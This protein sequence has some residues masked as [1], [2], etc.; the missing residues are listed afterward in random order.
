M[1]STVPQARNESMLSAI[2][3]LH[4]AEY[5][6]LMTR[7]T[8][9]DQFGA[10]VWGLMGAYV[11]FLATVWHRA[12]ATSYLAWGSAIGVEVMLTAIVFFMGEHYS[13]VLYLETVL[14]PLVADLGVDREFW[15]YQTFLAKGRQA[16]SQM[17]W[18]WYPPLIAVVPI[19]IVL[20]WR[21]R[22]QGWQHGDWVGFLA[23][24]LPV[25]VLVFLCRGLVN[26][27]A[28]WTEELH[29]R[30]QDRFATRDEP[31]GPGGVVNEGLIDRLRLP[32]QRESAPV[33]LS[34]QDKQSIMAVACRASRHL[35]QHY[36]V[37]FGLFPSARVTDNFYNQV[38]ARDCAHAAGNYFA[39][40]DPT[41]V[42]DS[43]ATIF[44]YQ[45][46]NG[47]LPFK[48]EREYG[49][50]K[51][52]PGCRS[53][54]KRLF[55]L[56]ERRMRKRLER[57]VYE[58]EDFSGAEDT[59]PVVIIAAGELFM[60]S[61][62]GRTF[63]RDY[64]EHMKRA[65]EFFRTKTDPTDGL[66]VIATDNSDWADSLTR[67]GKL[68]GVNVLWARALRLMEYVSR[69]LG[70]KDDAQSYRDEFR[71]VKK[72]VIKTL[73]N[74]PTGYF[75]AKEGEDRL[76]T[77][78]SIFG[79]LYLLPP[80]EAKRV[81]E[82]LKKVRRA[83]GFQNFAPAYGGNEIFWSHRLF[84]MGGYHNRFVWPWV[85]CQNIQVKIKI[86][87]Q[88][89]DPAVR[90]QYRREAIDD[91]LQSS[92]LFR[93]VGGAYEIV[94]PDEPEP[95]RLLFY[96]PPTNF[97]GSLAAYQGAYGQLRRIGWI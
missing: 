30:E 34:A 57:P 27:R 72:S 38:F 7:A 6:A 77:V 37:G 69:E 3:Q 79:A 85:T 80:G 42:V 50:V 33:P 64:L 45:R 26:V 95:G 71:K 10:Y 32:R 21:W 84:R 14:H 22:V 53:L 36:Y 8:Y 2:I 83:S 73:Y 40:A 56:I 20:W 1:D 19:V 46:P 94:N 52:I 51:S 4:A 54:D 48:V 28:R 5:G 63:V 61:D 60:C 9:E 31:Q 76:D 41:A 67:K 87:L 24:L 49:L 96:R 91:F 11:L 23:S 70:L 97:M 78:A 16:Q 15:R 35:R 62:E 88:H 44:K 29:E 39:Y 43:L 47:M 90:S 66:A 58:G 12:G 82:T 25:A 92:R 65:I 17:Y 13:I 74:H 86:G 68:G 18:E 89:N 59:V 93:S 75:R 81:E 55:D